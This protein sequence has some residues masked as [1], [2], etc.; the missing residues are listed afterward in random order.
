LNIFYSSFDKSA[1]GWS[2]YPFDLMRK[3][4]R[5]WYQNGLERPLESHRCRG[6][7][8][9]WRV[10]NLSSHKLAA[11]AREESRR[12][13]AISTSYRVGG[14]V[15]SKFIDSQQ[16]QGERER[17]NECSNQFSKRCAASSRLPNGRIS[18]SNI[19]FYGDLVLLRLSLPLFSLFT[20]R[21][22]AILRTGNQYLPSAFVHNSRV[23]AGHYKE[24]GE[25]GREMQKLFTAR[26]PRRRA[27]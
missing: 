23:S 7:R 2:F 24:P 25:G 4:L 8:K 27:R 5:L 19:D 14:E 9:V 16:A 10:K 18:I 1:P 11:R 12:R 15:S 26:S 20:S 6:S 3:A 13:Q 22:D 17:P 21:G